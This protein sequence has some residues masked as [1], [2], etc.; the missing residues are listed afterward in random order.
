MERER[1]R[2]RNRAALASRRENAESYIIEADNVVMRN[3]GNVNNPSEKTAQWKLA[4]EKICPAEMRQ[5]QRLG[6]GM[7]ELLEEVEAKHVEFANGDSDAESIRDFEGAAA[8]PWCL[9]RRWPRAM[10]ASGGRSVLPWS[11]PAVQMVAAA[12][13][14]GQLLQSA[15]YPCRRLAGV[16]TC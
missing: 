6:I 13:A 9:P 8:M 4:L 15:P 3:L 5:A 16:L 7:V 12:R 14:R 11:L 1:R 2:L 10:R